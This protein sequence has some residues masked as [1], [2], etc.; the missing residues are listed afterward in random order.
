MK[1]TLKFMKAVSE[2]RPFVIYDIESSGLNK[3]LDE[4]IE[5]SAIV[6]SW[7]PGGYKMTDSIECF[8]K[9]S[10][11]ISK[12]SIAVHGFTNEYL[13]QFPGEKE[14]FP[15]IKAF[16]EKHKDAI[17]MGYNQKRFDD[18]MMKSLCCRVGLSLPELFDEIDVFDMVKEN[19]FEKKRNLQTMHELLCPGIEI[20]YHDSSGDIRA[21]WNV[22]VA[23]YK[24]CIKKMNQKKNKVVYHSHTSAN[25]GRGRNYLFVTVKDV[26]SNAFLNVFY[27]YYYKCWKGK[28]VADID[29]IDIPD[30][31]NQLRE[32]CPGVI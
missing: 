16:L 30:L 1:E 32:K 9:P 24:R 4:V 25:Y 20:R 28:D 23:L 12:E 29:G 22:A 15:V 2:H 18:E 26:S 7:E 11:E 5:Y 31:E 6:F 17:L 13:S 21:T 3:T 27:D 19:I 10:F 14:V 8:I